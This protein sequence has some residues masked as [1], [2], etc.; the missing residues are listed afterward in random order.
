MR[1][2]PLRYYLERVLRDRGGGIS[3]WAAKASPELRSNHDYVME[4]VSM[5]GNALQFASAQL[6]AES[7]IVKM[8]VSKSGHALEFASQKLR[9]DREIVMTALSS[10]G[11]A[12]RF[13]S[14]E[15]RFDR[16]CVMTA[17]SQSGDALEFA[18]E[19]LRSDRDLVLAAVFNN[20][21]ALLH[22]S[23]ELRSD[24]DVIGRAA[25]GSPPQALVLKVSVL[26]G[27]SCTLPFDLR[28]LSMAGLSGVLE[29]LARCLDLKR[30][31]TGK[32]IIGTLVKPDGTE[33][34]CADEL[35]PGMLNEVTLVIP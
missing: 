22:T 19:E 2:P 4:A 20:W 12:L 5:D 9:S 35:Q 30:A 15:L 34:S 16:D 3:H 21:R 7:D 25:F 33:I 18:L 23:E 1:Y 14:E 17:V 11:S 32:R 6:R 28:A 26:S 31:G 13:A 24:P 27:R 29:E 8:A 10:Y